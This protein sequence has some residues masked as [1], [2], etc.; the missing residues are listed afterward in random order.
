[1]WDA[2]TG[3]Q[4]LVLGPHKGAITAADLSSDGRQV[5]LALQSSGRHSVELWDGQT[6]KKALT[7]PQDGP[8]WQAP[9]VGLS[10]D[11]RL[12]VTAS[13]DET[14]RIWEVASGKELTT[15]TGHQD[16]VR[17]A[18]FSPDGKRVATASADGT[19]RLWMLDLLSAALARKPRELTVDER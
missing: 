4:L 15:L 18:T 12:V 6:G 16:E 10:P 17:F 1:L 8:T 3:K 2:A 5:L 19:A 11:G 14:A 9:V 13:E 7:L